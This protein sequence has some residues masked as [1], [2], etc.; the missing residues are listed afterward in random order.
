MWTGYSQTAKRD[1]LSFDQTDQMVHFFSIFVRVSRRKKHCFS[2]IA[3][4]TD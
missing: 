3:V 2:T 4:L 1:G